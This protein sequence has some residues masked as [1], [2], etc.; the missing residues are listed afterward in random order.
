[1]QPKE[2][3]TPFA[4]VGF[5]LSTAI[6]VVFQIYLI[7]E[8]ARIIDDMEADR[9]AAVSAGRDL[10][11]E[12]CS[13]CH[14]V[15][16]EGGIGP[17]LN[18]RQFLQIASDKALFN[19]TITGVPGTTMPAWGQEFGGPFT[20]EEASQLVAFIRSWDATA[21]EIE[22]DVITPDPV[23]GATIFATTC[24]VCHGKNGQGTEITRALN[25]P[26]RL[27]DFDNA[28]YRSTISFGRPAKGMPTW[29]TVLSPQ[30]LDDLTALIDAWR[31]GET[32]LS[33]IPLKTRLK[34]ALFALRQF[35]IT[36]ALV[37]LNEGLSLADRNQA[38]TIREVI[39]LMEA[40]KI[41]AAKNLL[42]VLLP[43]SE[44]GEELYVSYCA[45]CHGTDGS[46]GLGTNLNDNLYIQS[47]EDAE[48]L[49]FLLEGRSGT[50][51]EGYKGLLM[52][53]QIEDIVAFLRTLQ[54]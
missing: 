8:P 22:E 48:L 26:S 43:P 45:A 19:L 31:N 5:I 35:N 21:Q 14:G 34:S 49:T 7:R 32:V 4:I 36:D 16:G 53:L 51:M 24:F 47:Q 23:R 25:D 27:D 18:S 20:N 29:G 12:N 13:S 37:H 52:E 54:E 1:M 44:I 40:D 11:E 39:T 2:N 3:Y 10:Y 17:A 42:I 15:F 30:Q 28:W 6:F 33:D 9:V 46:G 41:V 38:E 50:A